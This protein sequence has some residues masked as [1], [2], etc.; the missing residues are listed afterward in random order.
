MGGADRES[1]LFGKFKSV[2]D[3]NETNARIKKPGEARYPT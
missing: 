2:E 3:K 1:L